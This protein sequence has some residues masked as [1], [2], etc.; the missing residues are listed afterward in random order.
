MHQDRCV[1]WKLPVQWSQPECLLPP[2][3]LFNIKYEGIFPADFTD[4]L[5]AKVCSNFFS[6]IPGLQGRMLEL[7]ECLVS[8][9]A[10]YRIWARADIEE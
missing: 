4:A 8:F 6:L 1:Q 2:L 9:P 3:M 7:V 5:R 10:K